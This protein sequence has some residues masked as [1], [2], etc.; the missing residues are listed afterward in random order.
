MEI[1]IV[2]QDFSLTTESAA[3]HLRFFLS[4]WFSQPMFFSRDTAN[5]FCFRAGAFPMGLR[6]TVT[7]RE[8]GAN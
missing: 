1:E 8:G 3:S 7:R 6:L 2:S 5:L 4:H